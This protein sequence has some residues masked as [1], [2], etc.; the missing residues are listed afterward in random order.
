MRP[1]GSTGVNGACFARDT[2][3]S[4][5]LFSDPVALGTART[6]GKGSFSLL[7]RIPS[8]TAEGNHRIVAQGAGQSASLLLTVSRGLSVTGMS[9]NL[10]ILG[11]ALLAAGVILLA[12]DRIARQDLIEFV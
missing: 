3:V 5:T 8:N 10:A 7:V 2:D 12:G 9:W 4:L 11:L 1:G 6:D